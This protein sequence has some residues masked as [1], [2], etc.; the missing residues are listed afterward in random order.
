MIDW[1]FASENENEPEFNWIMSQIYV[2]CIT[3]V[4][5]QYQS[6]RL[7]CVLL[8]LSL[9]L[10]FIFSCINWVSICIRW[11]CYCRRIWQWPMYSIKAKRCR[12]RSFSDFRNMNRLKEISV[13]GIRGQQPGRKTRIFFIRRM[14]LMTLKLW[15]EKNILG[16]LKLKTS[17]PF[18]IL[19]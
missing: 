5:I 4:C 10:L 7:E 6:A 13:Q 17:T 16:T 19:F 2:D 11:A 9:L 14:K 18:Y 15:C 12:T 1:D 3:R 8:L